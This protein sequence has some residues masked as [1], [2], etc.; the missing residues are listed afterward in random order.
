M[1]LQTLLLPAFLLFSSAPLL[2]EEAPAA[3]KSA[4]AV[5]GRINVN[6]ADALTLTGLKGVGE[7]KAQAII[8]YRKSKGPFN[9]LEQLEAVPGIGPSII[10]K[11]KSAIVFR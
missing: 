1:R 10:A 11:N 4:P 7:K 9:S 8:A 2:A 3:A 5:V 6:T